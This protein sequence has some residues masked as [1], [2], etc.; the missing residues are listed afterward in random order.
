MTSTD[1]E[2]PPNKK[3]RFFQENS[4][5]IKSSTNRASIDDDLDAFPSSRP[6]FG[7]QSSDTADTKPTKGDPVSEEDGVPISGFDQ[8]MFESIVC[9]KVA[10]ELMKRL[11]EASGDNMDRAVN[12][13]FDGSWKTAAK[14]AAPPKTS[15]HSGT[16]TMNDF[17]KTSTGSNGMNGT[18]A[19]AQKGESPGTSLQ[20]SMP[21]Y[22]YVGAFGVEGWATR[23]GTTLIKFGDA[24]K[25]ERQKIQPPKALVKGR[26]SPAAIQ[27]PK[28]NSAAAKRVDVVVRF[29]NSRG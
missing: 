11:R 19:A 4:D 2:G 23:S 15:A 24:V 8:D 29:T 3:R 13:Y 6:T 18:K 14:T 20:D 26:G 17:A 27:A 28:P 22:R 5:G 16:L 9:E 25:I 12:L 21:D 10:P 7:H 1:M